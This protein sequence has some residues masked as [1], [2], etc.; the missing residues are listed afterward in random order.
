MHQYNHNHNIH[1]YDSVISVK[2]QQHNSKFSKILVAID[3]SA[4][5]MK[6]AE[7]TFTMADKERNEQ[8]LI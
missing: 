8:R 6:A 2:D 7:V 4:A 5:S 1:L 3:G